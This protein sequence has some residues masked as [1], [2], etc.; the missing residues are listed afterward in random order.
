MGQYENC[1]LKKCTRRLC[2][3]GNG[4][5]GFGGPLPRMLFFASILKFKSL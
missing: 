5:A 2:T 3:R 4:K 1:Y